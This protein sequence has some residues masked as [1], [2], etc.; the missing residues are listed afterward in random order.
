MISDVDEAFQKIKAAL[1]KYHV[2]VRD[3]SGFKIGMYAT[4]TKHLL[5]QRS[6][7]MKFNGEVDVGIHGKD[8]PKTHDFWRKVKTIRT[9]L[10]PH[11]VDDFVSNAIS[12]VSELRQ[13]AICTGIT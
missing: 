7:Y 1:P 12:I 2:I 10:L 3:A 8:L 11:T 9:P 4:T 13:F 6:V 5:V